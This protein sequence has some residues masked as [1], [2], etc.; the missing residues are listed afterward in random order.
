M[1]QFTNGRCSH[2]QFILHQLQQDSKLVH[3][4]G[5]TPDR[6]P[7]LVENNP[8]IATEALLRLSSSSK[9]NEY[10]AIPAFPVKHMR[11]QYT[12]IRTVYPFPCQQVSESF[13][14]G[15][16]VPALDGGREPTRFRG[17]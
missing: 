17:R 13:G 16:Y 6:L 15:Q 2:L 14:D 12:K 8:N 9:L 11:D 10:V 5:I 4:S 1:V 3:H 7:D